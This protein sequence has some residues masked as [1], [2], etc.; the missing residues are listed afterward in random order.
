[1]QD[2]GPEE[3]LKKVEAYEECTMSNMHVRSIKKYMLALS[4]SS[5]KIDLTTLNKSI[6][7]LTVQHT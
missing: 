3:D 7:D 2:T 6:V 1:M 5:L 4:W